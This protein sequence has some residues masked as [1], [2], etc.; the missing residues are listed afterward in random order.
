[1]EKNHDVELKTI[2]DHPYNA[3][4]PIEALSDDLTPADLIYVRNHF[5]IPSVGEQAWSIDVGGAVENPLELTMDDLR[6]MEPRALS[7][8]LECAG[9]GRKKMDP[10]PGGTPWEY[11]AVSI[12]EFAGT[13]LTNVLQMARIDQEV[14]E[15]Y[16]EGADSGEVSP[17][18]REPFARSLPLDIANHPDTLLAWEMNGEPLTAQ[19]GYPLRLV[20][21]GWYGMASVKWLKKVTARTKPFEGYFQ[22]ERYVYVADGS[23]DHAEPVTSICIRALI[24]RPGHTA[25]LRVNKATQIEGIAWSGESAVSKV[26][27]STDAGLSWHMA[28]VADPG[29][30]YQPQR[31]TYRWT[32]QSSGTFTLSCRAYDVAGNAQPTEQKWNEFGYGN[33][34]PHSISVEVVADG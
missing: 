25:V 4:T 14:T 20:V 31:W 19:H 9:N 3:G 5:A 23:I 34:G 12:V 21:P 26:E 13:S 10:L 33:N 29:N 16:F 30:K 32:P 17:G 6:S 11:G 8:T 27:V 24:I 1:M 18:R 28:Q 2:T 7:M 15:I 22:R